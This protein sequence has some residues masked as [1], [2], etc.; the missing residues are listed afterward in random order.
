VLSAPTANLAAPRQQPAAGFIQ[1]MNDRLAELVAEHPGRLLALGTID[2]F[3]G[4]Q[5]AREVE[6]VVQELGFGGIVVDCALGDC[7]LDAPEARPTLEAAAAL[8]AVVFIHPVSPAGYTER[9]AQIGPTGVL[10]ARGNETAASVLGLLR[11]GVF[12]ALPELHAVIPAIGAAGLIFAAQADREL[13]REAGW[14]G[15][16]PSEA[17]KRLYIDT[18]GLDPYLIRFAV[19]LLGIEHVLFGTDW[20]I[21]PIANRDHVERALIAAG[22]TAP[23]DQALILSGNALR[24]LGRNG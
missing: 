17:R 11:G 24:L 19:N 14:Q 1:Q 20:P 22:I 3:Q 18:M 8:G 21:M 10:L 9:L 16:L 12:D 7:F 13:G 6:R 2:A 15:S 5:A 4:E 23:G